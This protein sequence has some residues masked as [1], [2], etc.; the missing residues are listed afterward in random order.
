M[1]HSASFKSLTN[2][3]FNSVLHYFSRI[4]TTPYKTHYHSHILT[5]FNHIPHSHFYLTE[6]LHLTFHTFL[7]KHLQDEGEGHTLPYQNGYQLCGAWC[8]LSSPKTI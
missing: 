5:D 7:H 3:E 6:F 8:S 4:L 2:T 1:P